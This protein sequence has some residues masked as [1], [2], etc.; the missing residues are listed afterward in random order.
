MSDSAADRLTA[1]VLRELIDS[2]TPFLV[3]FDAHHAHDDEAPALVRDSD[4]A[5]AVSA[6]QAAG[7]AVASGTVPVDRG[8][9]ISPRRR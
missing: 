7:C 5:R 6:L 9:P 8:K 2:A 4:L 1:A 3:L